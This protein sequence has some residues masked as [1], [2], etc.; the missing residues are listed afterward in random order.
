MLHLMGIDTVVDANSDENITSRCEKTTGHFFDLHLL[1]WP[2][3]VTQ[4]Y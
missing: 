3:S 2:R 1:L 4:R